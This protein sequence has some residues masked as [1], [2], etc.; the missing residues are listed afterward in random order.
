MQVA[1]VSIPVSD[2]ERAKSFY[3]GTLGWE[4]VRDDSTPGLRWLQVRPDAGAVSLALVDWFETM[5]AGST[6]GLVLTVPDLDEAY[7]HLMARGI[8]FDGPPQAR[9]WGT[10]T[11][12]RDPDGNQ[13]VLQQAA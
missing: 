2:Q 5:P 6:R 8:E 4:L 12:F 9:P 3:V 13:C 7:R 11:V 1:V 10:E